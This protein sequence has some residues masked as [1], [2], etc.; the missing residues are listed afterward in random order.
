MKS[1]VKMVQPSGI[2]IKARCGLIVLLSIQP[3]HLHSVRLHFI[4]D[5]R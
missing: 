2:G 5:M 4:M 3:G 1:D